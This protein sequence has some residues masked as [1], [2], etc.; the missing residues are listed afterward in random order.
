MKT[1]VR[2]RKGVWLLAKLVLMAVG[3]SGTAILGEDALTVQK[4]RSAWESSGAFRSCGLAQ[5]H[6]VLANISVDDEQCKVNVDCSTSTWGI[7]RNQTW[8]G[9]KEDMA[10]L[11]NCN[12]YLKLE[13]C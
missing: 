7:Y 9:S 3:L 11:N 8:Q 10:K 4:C 5:V 1:H 6:N 13:N 12:G 2:Q